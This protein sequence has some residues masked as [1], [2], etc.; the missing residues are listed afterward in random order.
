M[1]S[2][3]DIIPQKPLDSHSH[4]LS[5]YRSY[6]VSKVRSRDTIFPRPRVGRSRSR[7][8][9]LL[10]MYG[11]KTIVNKIEDLTKLTYSETKCFVMLCKKKHG[12][13]QRYD[14]VN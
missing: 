7:K 14:K 11:C 12:H 3:V 13:V 4:E 8:Q 6:L 5:G 2:F 10:I 1:L 9:R